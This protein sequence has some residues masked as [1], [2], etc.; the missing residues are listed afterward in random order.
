MGRTLVNEHTGDLIK[1]RGGFSEKG[2][3]NFDKI[4]S[5]KSKADKSEVSSN[6]AKALSEKTKRLVESESE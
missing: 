3:E 5:N 4:F 1:T 2:A 6:D